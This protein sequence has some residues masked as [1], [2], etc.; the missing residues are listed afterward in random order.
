MRELT[1]DETVKRGCK[2]CIDMRRGKGSKDDGSKY[3]VRIY[4]CPHNRCPYHELDKYD[5]YD[6]YLKSI[7]G[8]DSIDNLLGI[9]EEDSVKS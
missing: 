7:V 5:T 4:L 2:Y 1:R 8:K 6:E 3:L 9:Q